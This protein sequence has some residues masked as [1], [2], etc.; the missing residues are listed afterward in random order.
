MIEKLYK[1]FFH[2]GLQKNPHTIK[3]GFLSAVLD[4]PH[5]LNDWLYFNFDIWFDYVCINARF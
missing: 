2:K 3:I 5:Y 1:H 4:M